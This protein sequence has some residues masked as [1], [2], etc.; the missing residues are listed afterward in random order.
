MGKVSKDWEE[1]F[2]KDREVRERAEGPLHAIE[3][4]L[5]IQTSRLSIDMTLGFLINVDKDEHENEGSH[6]PNIAKS[7]SAYTDLV[8]QGHL[9]INMLE[10]RFMNVLI[11][12]KSKANMLNVGVIYHNYNK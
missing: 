12:L 3:D 9:K 7:E 5:K 10:D 6:G 8:L 11:H 2:G 4:I 1:I